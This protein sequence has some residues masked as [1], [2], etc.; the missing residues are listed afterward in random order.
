MEQS[1]IEESVSVSPSSVDKYSFCFLCP[2]SDSVLSFF[3]LRTH[4]IPT[5][6][7]SLVLLVR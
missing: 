4:Y 5:S 7:L 3:S 2:W 1:R 6:L